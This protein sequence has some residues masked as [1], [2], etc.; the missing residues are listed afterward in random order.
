MTRYLLPVLFLAGSLVI[1]IY[2]ATHDRIAAWDEPFWFMRAQ[3]APF[4]FDGYK[5]QVMAVDQLALQRWVFWPALRLTGLDVVGPDERPI[6]EM[7]DGHM[8]YL[9]RG[10]VPWRTPDSWK[11]M[12]LRRYTVEEWNDVHGEYAPRRAIVLLRLVNVCMYGLMLVC[13]WLAARMALRSETLAILPA[14]PFVL[15]P[16]WNGHMSFILASGD[17]FLLCGFSATLALWLRCHLGGGA[18]WKSAMALGVLGG[19]TTSAKH[20]GVLV[21]AAVCGYLFLEG[22]R[23]LR[24]ELPLLSFAVAVCVFVALNPVIWLCPGRTP[25]EVLS[26]ISR[27]RQV[28]AAEVAAANLTVPISQ[29]S[30]NLSFLWAALPATVMLAWG[31]RTNRWLKPVLWWG[32]F[33]AVGVTAGLFALLDPQPRYF[34]P[35]ELAV[36]F[37]LTLCGTAIV[38]S[39]ALR[40]SRG[41]S[42]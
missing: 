17:V 15:L 14:L 9:E 32:C 28:H 19:L 29:M 13:L 39:A 7:K 31:M 22:R 40:S 4:D 5:H 33:I 41:T 20:P 30:Q 16:F 24:L 36:F 1:P 6:W 25:A 11:A 34:A 27:C 26:W 12:D 35:V 21:V 8:Y 2:Q 10:Y 37:T 23:W 18:S 38:S 3:V 42:S